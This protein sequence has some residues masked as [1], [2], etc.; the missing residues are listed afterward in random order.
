ML[1]Q[2][3]TL[4]SPKCQKL[5]R[6]SHSLYIVYNPFPGKSLASILQ[7]KVLTVTESKEFNNLVLTIMLMIAGEL[8]KLHE[9]GALLCNFDESNIYIDRRNNIFFCDW[10]FSRSINLSI[11]HSYLDHL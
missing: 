11:D 3:K 2:I 1:G 5:I 6:T 9:A 10:T 7:E 4:S 8:K